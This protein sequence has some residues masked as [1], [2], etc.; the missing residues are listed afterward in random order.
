[1]DPLDIGLPYEVVTGQRKG[2]Y[3]QSQDGW[4]FLKNQT[5]KKLLH[6]S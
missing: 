6:L 4:W 1:M 5:R 3:Y 2:K